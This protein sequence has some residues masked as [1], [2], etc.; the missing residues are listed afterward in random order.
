[1]NEIHSVDFDRFGVNILSDA[2]WGSIVLQ[3]DISTCGVGA[4]GPT[5]KAVQ[6][7]FGQGIWGHLS[8]WMT[9]ARGMLVVTSHAQPHPDQP[10]VFVVK[11]AVKEGERMDAALGALMDFFRT[12]PGYRRPLGPPLDPDA[13]HGPIRSGA[14]DAS[15]AAADS[16]RLFIEG[17]RRKEPRR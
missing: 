7:R 13:P 3:F 4:I 5:L 15:R 9:G 11:M 10:D 2:E 16:L 14:G 12:Q 6:R 1:M 8:R 17:R